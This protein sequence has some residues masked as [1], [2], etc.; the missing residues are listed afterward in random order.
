M[1]IFYDTVHERFNT[2]TCYK[3][4]FHE[5]VMG[6]FVCILEIVLRKGCFEGKCCLYELWRNLE[7]KDAVYI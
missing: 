7:A 1:R 3:K 5:A 6:H 2:I 4:E